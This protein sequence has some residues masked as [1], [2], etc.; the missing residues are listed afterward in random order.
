MSSL[1]GGCGCTIGLCLAGS[2]LSR[3][4]S[5]RPVHII[6]SS[7]FICT[8][9]PHLLLRITPS[10]TYFQRLPPFS[11]CAVF[12]SSA[13][14][15]MQESHKCDPNGSRRGCIQ[16]RPE[17]SEKQPDI[18]GKLHITVARSVYNGMRK[19]CKQKPSTNERLY[20]RRNL[21]SSLV[22]YPLEDEK[23]KYQT[24]GIAFLATERRHAQRGQKQS[25][26]RSR[27]HISRFYYLNLYQLW[28]GQHRQITFR[29]SEN[30]VILLICEYT[31]FEPALHV[32]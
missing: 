32:L 13:Y 28:S 12:A 14:D 25:C 18:H 5:T 27:A 24:Y 4:H 6:S 9:H 2:L 19:A 1:A 26:R 8:A 22:C 17:E 31:K 7:A 16:S 30:S 21:V 10:D 29:P 23:A 20:R 11:P 15:L 3:D